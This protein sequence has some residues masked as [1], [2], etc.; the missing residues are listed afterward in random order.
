MRVVA[1]L[2]LTAGLAFSQAVTPFSVIEVTRQ[3]DPA[4]KITSESG[5]LFAMNRDGSIASVD[6]SPAARGTRQII[7]V[8]KRR[9]ILVI[10]KSRSAAESTSASSLIAASDPC[11]LRFRKMAGAV[12]SVD[13]SAGMINGVPL[14]RISV[15]LPGGS[16]FEV[17]V[18]PSL[19]CHLMET[20]NFRNGS[21]SRS[22]TTE[23]LQLADP[24]PSLFEVPPDYQ[25]TRATLAQ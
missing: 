18:A 22:Q 10:P 5:F 16:A 8:T 19:A 13:R 25:L 2:L 4:G 17:L 7:D 21:V 12:V 23:N 3:F 24:D 20:R 14:E 9:T 6:L 11:D 15:V 1:G